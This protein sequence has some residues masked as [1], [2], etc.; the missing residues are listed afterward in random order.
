T[1]L[2]SLSLRYGYDDSFDPI[3]CHL[4]KLQGNVGGISSK[5]IS[6]AVSAQLNSTLSNSL[7][8]NF[9]FGWNHIYATF[10]C[11]GLD[12]LD[13]VS[14]L[15]AFGNGSD[16][17]MDPFTSFG[18]LDLVANNQF[19]KTGT[20]SYGDSLSWVKGAHTFKFGADFRNIAERGPDNF[21][22][23]RQVSTDA[24]NE[25][26][27]SLIN[28]PLNDTTALEDAA[29]AFY[30]F[31]VSDFTGEFFNKSGTRI[32]TDDRRFR[33]HEYDWFVQDAWK[34][35]RNLTLSLGARYQLDGVPYEQD[36][37]FS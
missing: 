28:A 14:T 9:N 34:I 36:A 20:T 18:C 31:V 5:S 7:I 17:I 3:P 1:D 10:N 30:G 13:S 22:S 33:Q 11:T 26:G 35:R 25:F 19:R 16:Y 15:D 24:N 2:H 37:N 21:F 23:R 29:S 8:N 32:A 6:Q 4:D 12:V 27:V